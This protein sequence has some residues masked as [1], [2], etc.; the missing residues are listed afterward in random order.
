M[1]SHEDNCSSRLQKSAI[2]VRLLSRVLR[3]NYEQHASW[4][5]DLRR[6]AAKEEGQSE[7]AK[8]EPPRPVRNA[9]IDS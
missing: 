5:L 1:P 8:L 7:L 2:T 4:R 6:F 9:R 3:E